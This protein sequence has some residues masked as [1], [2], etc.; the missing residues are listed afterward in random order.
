M[1]TPTRRAPSAVAPHPTETL[2]SEDG[3]RKAFGRYVK[4]QRPNRRYDIV[5]TWRIRELVDGTWTTRASGLDR[6]DA[7]K[8]ISGGVD[9]RT[10]GTYDATHAGIPPAHTGERR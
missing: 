9:D 1:K 6:A 2:I 7:E 5:Q 8:F 10:P 3:S 4:A